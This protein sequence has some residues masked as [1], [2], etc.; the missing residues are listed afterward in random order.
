MDRLNEEY[1]R[2]AANI[3]FLELGQEEFGLP[4]IDPT[5]YDEEIKILGSRSDWAPQ[6]LSEVVRHHP[7]S[8]RVLEAVLQ[9]QNFTHPQLIHFFFDVVKMNSANNDAVYQYAILNMDHDRHLLKQCERN[10]KDVSPG[11]VLS[12]LRKSDGD[13]DRRLVIAVFKMAVTKHAKDIPDNPDILRLRISDPVFKES[14]YRFTDYIIHQ[15]RLNE[16]LQCTDLV[17]LLK[18]KRAPHD[19]KSMHGAYGKKKVVNVLERNGFTNID[20]ILDEKRV[21]CLGN[22]LSLHLGSAIPD[23]RLFCTE[24]CVEGVVKPKGQ[25][26]KK[27]DV[28]IFSGTRPRHLLEINFYT[29]SGT[30]IG[31]NEGEYIDMSESIKKSEIHQF[32]WIT[33]GNHWLTPGGRK[34]LVRL[35]SQYQNIYNINTFEA[36]LDRFV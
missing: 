1:V 34:T 35:F 17:G 5:K 6:D 21:Q 10:L 8:F 20:I 18:S 26:P 33:D 11:A 12:Q 29:S 30:K 22:D 31:I 15:L 25:R 36:S 24:R 27:F 7:R 23:G 13:E 4:L 16:L 14:S 9:Q 19:T 2:F 28:I 32:H 3:S